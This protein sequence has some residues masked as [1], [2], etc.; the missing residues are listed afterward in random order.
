MFYK[1]I[2]LYFKCILKRKQEKCATNPLMFSVGDF[3][4]CVEYMKCRCVDVLMCFQKCM[5]YRGTS[6]DYPASQHNTVSTSPFESSLSP[7]LQKKI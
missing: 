5:T 7:H 3:C 6:G 4:L 2:I 1:V